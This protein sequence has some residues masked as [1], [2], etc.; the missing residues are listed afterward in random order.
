MTKEIFSDYLDDVRRV[1]EFFQTFAFSLD[2]VPADG[3]WTASQCLAHI[4]DAEIS[5]SLRIRMILTSENYQFSSW[6]ED[7]FASIK[8]DRDAR[9]SVET[10]K[11]L[12]KNN[13]NLLEGMSDSQ[14]RRVG[15]K[16]NGEPIA[17][18]DYVAYMSKH[19][20][21]HLEQAVA[22]AQ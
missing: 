6:D 3:G 22:A 17:L 1:E 19:V 4:C 7:A 20:R 9:V 14:L 15:I 10:F 13:H 12:R 11:I 5:L 8:K 18:I 2:K 21:T 16:A